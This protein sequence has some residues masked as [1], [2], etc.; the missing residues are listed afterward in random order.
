MRTTET[1]MVYRARLNGGSTPMSLSSDIRRGSWTPL[2]VGADPRAPY[3]PS[4][5]ATGER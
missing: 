5:P 4:A 1:M 2:A 3:L